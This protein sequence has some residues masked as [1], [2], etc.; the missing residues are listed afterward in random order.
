MIDDKRFSKSLA[1]KWPLVLVLLI[2]IPLFLTGCPQFLRQAPTAVI[3]AS[4]TSGAPPLDVDFDGSGSSDPDGTIASYAWNFGDGDTDTGATVSHTY[5]TEGTF[6]ATLTVT[7]NN[8]LTNTASV[9]INVTSAAQQPHAII[10]ADPTEGEA[11]LTV[12]F[13]GSQSTDPDG[14]DTSLTYSWGFGDGGTSTEQKPSHEFTGEGIYKVVLTV[15]DG[16]GLEGKDHVFI[17]TLTASIYFASNRSDYEIYRMD[18][19][20]S[21]QA[22]VTDNGDEDL[23]PALLYNTRLKLAF[24]SD[25]RAGTDFDIFKSEVDGTLPTNLTPSQTASEQIEPSWNND[26]SEITYASDQSGDWEIWTMNNDGS[27]KENLSSQTSSA[28]LAPVFSPDGT[29]IAYVSDSG[30]T[31]DTSLWTMDSD[32]SNQTE[33]YDSSGDCDGSCGHNPSGIS[34]PSG[35]GASTPSWS[36][37][38]TKIA[39]TSNKDGDLDIYVVDSDGSNLKSITPET[40]LNDYDNFDPFWLP[41]GDEIAFVVEDGGSYEIWKVDVS[42]LDNPGGVTL[43]T[44][45]GDNLSPSDELWNN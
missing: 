7:D 16:D 23:W 40:G 30:H 2:L 28:E 33:I 29:K 8:G 4:P 10:E 5:D 12:Q 22:Q 42:D 39:F 35:F 18:T 41:N 3:D 44:D 37:D 25:R 20:G 26:G 43:L 21:N 31:G 32:G 6:N 9:P 45:L 34:L 1:D 15:T 27:G 38:G 11:P 24:A 13:D 36:P 19:D 17:N 14:P